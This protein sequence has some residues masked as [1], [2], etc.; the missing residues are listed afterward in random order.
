MTKESSGGGTPRPASPGARLWRNRDFTIFWLGQTLSGL[1]DAVALIALPLLVLQATGSVAQMGLVTGTFGAT[2]LVAGLVAG[3]LVDT[4]DRRRLMIGCDLG[5]AVSY[6]LIPVVWLLAGPQVW[7]IYVTTV[8]GALGGYV[9]S[10]GAVTVVAHLVDDTQVTEANGRLQLS[11]G[12]SVVTGPALAGL[13]IARSSPTAAIGVDALSFV[14]SAATLLGVRLHRRTAVSPAACGARPRRSDEWLAGLRFLMRQ[15]LLRTLTL[16]SALANMVLLGA[17]DLVIYR[18][19]HEL[20]QGADAVG[21]I[22]GLAGLGVI[23]AGMVTPVLRRHLGFGVCWIGGLCGTGLG[24]VGFA[25]TSSTPLIVLMAVLF[26]FMNTITYITNRSV[27]QEITPP[28]LL[29]RVTAAFWTLSGAAAPIGAAVTTAL[30]ARLGAPVI[31]AGMGA[32]ITIVAL[33]S[34]DTPVNHR[35]PEKHYAQDRSA[36]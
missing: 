17:T 33:L 15:P 35:R 28:P 5:R 2:E 14:I 27:R 11:N 31:L 3:A 18:L 4:L 21:V 8:L 13:L 23:V 26:S 36:I 9:F 1:G 19:K 12:L 20:H 7:L 25:F 32:I 34:I 29:G 16:V 30:A 22:V 6:A 10:V 24:L